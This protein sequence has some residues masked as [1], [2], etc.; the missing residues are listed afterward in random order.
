MSDI[1]CATDL[2][3]AADVALHFAMQIADRT[4][5]QVTLLHVVKEGEGTGPEGLSHTGRLDDQIKRMNGSERV[6]KLLLEGRFLDRIPEE[7]ARGHALTILG[8]HGPRGLR[9]NLFGADILKLV[10]KLHGP[11]LIVQDGTTTANTF[12]R[13]V[14]P[15]AAH[16]DIDPLVDA[17]CLLAR[18]HA[19]EVHIYQLVRVNEQPSD[20]L[21]RNKLHMI[22]RLTAAN[23][24]HMEVNEPS[25]VFS[26]GFAEPT[27]RYAQRIDA[28][29]IA[30]MAHASDELRY[31]AD[32]EKERMLT[33]EP[34][35]P[36]LCA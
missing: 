13:I 28:D 26:L 16:S 35:I 5:A 9:Q 3:P 22:E 15:V 29:C 17:V 31:L 34:R 24:R 4:S 8:T 32:A 10:R 11:S 2:S 18:L 19:S 33:N 12:D 25:S 36:V 30:I 14:M 1:L 21:L 20:Q 6:R 23:V 27:I 7:S